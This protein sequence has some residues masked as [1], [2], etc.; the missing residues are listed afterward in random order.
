MGSQAGGLVQGLKSQVGWFSN[1]ITG[2][3]AGSGVKSQV[4]WFSNGITGRWAGSGVK[5]QVGWFSNAVIPWDHRHAGGLVQRWNH[6][7]VGCEKESQV[8]WFSIEIA[9]GKTRVQ[10][11]AHTILN[12]LN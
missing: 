5:S 6:R 8:G 3:W 2:R 10:I 12:N 11:W 1:G 4:G 9:G 7:W